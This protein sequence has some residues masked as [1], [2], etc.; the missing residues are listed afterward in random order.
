MPL[1][2]RRH[3]TCEGIWEYDPDA[4][5]QIAARRP[6]GGVDRNWGPQRLIEVLWLTPS[7]E[8][9]ADFV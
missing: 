4:R 9:G 1:R 7:S 2:S 8:E 6:R 5:G 3:W